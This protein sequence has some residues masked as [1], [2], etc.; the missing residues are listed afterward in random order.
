MKNYIILGVT[1]CC[2]ASC[3]SPKKEP[4]AQQVQEDTTLVSLNLAQ[5]KNAGIVI[6]SPVEKDVNQVLKVQ[7]TVEV[8]PSGLV[9]V[10]FPLGGYLRRT[11]MVAGMP[12]KK[13]QVLGVL[14]DIAFIQ[15][16]QDFLQT[17]ATEDLALLE[18]KRQEE[19]NRSKASSDKVLQQAK[20]AWETQRINRKAL[21]E[22]LLLLGINP[23][24]LTASNISGTLAVRSPI[25]GFVSKVNVNPGKYTAPTDVLFELVNPK[26]IHLSVQVYEKDLSRLRAGQKLV[27]YTNANPDQK[28]AGTVEL[29]SRDLNADRMAEVHCHFSKSK[30]SLVPGM[31]M[32]AELALEGQRALTVPEEAVVRWQNAYYVFVAGGKQSFNMVPVQ[33]GNLQDGAQQ[34]ISVAISSD[35]KLVVANAYALLMKMKNTA[36][37]E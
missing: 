2:L 1:I 12:V 15:L 35:S 31:F 26:D 18:Y 34:I 29:I 6:G 24:G 22:K 37:E 8:P 7:G 27:A 13:G 5:I 21:A 25:D 9:S 16:Q 4:A 36:E 11:T 30:L 23:G 17:R 19:L 32:V 20:T 10:S 28:Y 14:E 3:S 33:L